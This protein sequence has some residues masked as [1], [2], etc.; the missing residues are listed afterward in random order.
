L[1]IWGKRG[2]VTG[3]EK[4]QKRNVSPCRGKTA[5]EISLS[6]SAIGKP[7]KK[8]GAGKD[9]SEIRAKRKKEG[10]NVTWG[11]DEKLPQVQKTNKGK[12]QTPR[13]LRS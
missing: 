6:F 4:G 2:K 9:G 1:G 7:R 3:T 8:I 10:W 13:G 12:L 5:R 11:K